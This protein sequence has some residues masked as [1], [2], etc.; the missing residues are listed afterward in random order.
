V[1]FPVLS[2]RR[3][4]DPAEEVKR[5]TQGKLV[6]ATVVASAQ[7]LKPFFKQLRQRVSKPGPSLGSSY[8]TS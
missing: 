3:Y 1:S 8:V 5:S 2:A 6:T 7:N 4:T